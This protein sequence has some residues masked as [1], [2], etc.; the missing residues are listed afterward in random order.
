VRPSSPWNNQ[1]PI[2]E[3]LF[4][5]ERLEEHARSLALAQAVASRTSRG[6]PLARRLADNGVERCLKETEDVRRT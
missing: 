4:S 6:Q 2:R 5:V 3:E 1:D